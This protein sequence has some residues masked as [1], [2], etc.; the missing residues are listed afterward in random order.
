MLNLISH[1]RYTLTDELTDR[2]SGIRSSLDRI[3]VLFSKKIFIN[4]SS[5]KQGQGERGDIELFI[6]LVPKDL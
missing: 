5:L 2:Q 1:Y 6:T 4:I 3:N